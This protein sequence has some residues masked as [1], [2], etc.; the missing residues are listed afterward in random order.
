MVI[1]H[2]IESHVRSCQQRRGGPSDHADRLQPRQKQLACHVLT[3][4]NRT[5]ISSVITAALD[6]AARIPAVKK[7]GC[8]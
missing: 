8:L 7:S 1:S 2:R 4:P 5:E 3:G 6:A